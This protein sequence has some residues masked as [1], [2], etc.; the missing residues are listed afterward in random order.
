MLGCIPNFFVGPQIK[1]TGVHPK[2]FFFFYISF[3][4]LY[5]C[6]SV[7]HHISSLADTPLS[8]AWYNPIMLI[9]TV[10]CVNLV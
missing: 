2:C 3:N 9:G 8:L 1:E 4:S 6:V 10:S 5:L 7:T